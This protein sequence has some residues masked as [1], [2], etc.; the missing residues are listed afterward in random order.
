MR[1]AILVGDYPG[2]DTDRQREVCLNIINKN[3]W[4]YVA[5]YNIETLKVDLNDLDAVVMISYALLG[6][7]EAGS[8][9]LEL[10]KS[11]PDVQLHSI[12]ECDEGFLTGKM[13]DYPFEEL[14]ATM[15]LATANYSVRFLHKYLDIVNW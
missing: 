3:G 5:I 14:R 7:K 13:A 6:N 11:Y 2:I 4:E 8:G 10:M 9:F 12:L 15:Q 1:A